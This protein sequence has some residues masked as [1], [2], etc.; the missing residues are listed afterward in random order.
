MN[1]GAEIT[2]RKVGNGFVVT[3]AYD[4]RHGG[5]TANEDVL[6]F[7]ELTGDHH[8]P[9]ALVHWIEGH[10]KDEPTPPQSSKDTSS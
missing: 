2:I 7:Q 1:K 4:M 9:N 5:I 3:P 6:V 10:F 8:Y